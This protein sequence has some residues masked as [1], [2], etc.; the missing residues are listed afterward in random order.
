M[1]VLSKVLWFFATPSNALLA[2][3]LLGVLLTASRYARVGRTLAV[4]A[5]VMLAICGLSPAA[6]WLIAPLENRFPQWAQGQGQPPTGMIVLGGS[7]DTTVSF[8]RGHGLELNEAAD[9]ITAMIALAREFPS[10]RIVFSGGQG[11]LL[12]RYGNEAEQIK[13][14][15]GRYGL[16]PERLEIENRSRTTFENA[17]E[18]ARMIAQKPGERWLLVT[19]AWHMPRSIAVFRAAGL[20]VEAYPVDFRTGGAQADMELFAEAS[21]GLRRFD[22]A[23]RE[24]IGL[25]GYR[26]AGASRELFPT[27]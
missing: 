10:A 2:I 14:N 22:I 5:L 12:A 23:T 21:R 24:W 8:H 18:A 3:A 9:R 19:S 13:T 1:F 15:I 27:P 25:L 20:K 26:L 17:T 4:T 16:P 7:L 11:A 6:N